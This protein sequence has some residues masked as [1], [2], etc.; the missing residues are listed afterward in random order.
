MAKTWCLFFVLLTGCSYWLRTDLMFGRCKPRPAGAAQCPLVSDEEWQQFVDQEIA[1]VPWVKDGAGKSFYLV[2]GSWRNLG[3]LHLEQIKY[4]LTVLHQYAIDAAEALSFC[5][6][7]AKFGRK[8]LEGISSIPK[9]RL[10][11]LPFA[12][13]VLE[14]LLEA[15]ESKRVV[16]SAHGLREGIVAEIQG[17]EIL[18]IDPVIAASQDLFKIAYQLPLRRP[19]DLERLTEGL[20]KAGLHEP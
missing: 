16:V 1:R 4:P 14:R 13:M 5:R 7:V 3:R 12:A 18:A 20:R 8:S 19:Q 2:G 15:V 17:P 6:S 9:K 11:G 10:E